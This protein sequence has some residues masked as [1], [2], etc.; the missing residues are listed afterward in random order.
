MTA[1]VERHLSVSR[2]E[3]DLIRREF[4]LKYGATLSGLVKHYQV[5]PHQFLRETHRFEDLHQL[6]KPTWAL[7]RLLRRLPGRKVLFTNAPGFYARRVLK[8]SGLATLFTRQ[9]SIENMQFAGRWQPKPSRPMFKR[10]AARLRVSPQR[11]VLIE[12]TMINLWAAKACGWRGVWVN[13]VSSDKRHGR[14]KV[15]RGRR[16]SVQVQSLSE[17]KRLNLPRFSGS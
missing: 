15:G 6:V 17:L 12:D 13:E 14:S 2:Q 9:I 4:L 16:V 10:S 11:I 5:D 1:F 8:A 3:A 7:A